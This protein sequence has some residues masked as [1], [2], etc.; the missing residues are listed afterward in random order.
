M[1]INARE[2]ADELLKCFPAVSELVNAGISEGAA[3]IIS[4]GYKL[5][6]ISNLDKGN[7]FGILDDLFSNYDCSKL[8]IGFF[9]LRQPEKLNDYEV[10]IGNYEADY[11]IANMRNGEIYMKE[12]GSPHHTLA[13]CANNIESFL[14]VILTAACFRKKKMLKQIVLNYE[15]I[16]RY[17]T[18]CIKVAGGEKYQ[19]FCKMMLGTLGYEQV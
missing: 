15:T 5:E 3:E 13:S 8:E 9:M 7:K 6:K 12:L 11:I 10:I 19:T 1:A 18:E 4:N 2:F 14:H 16:K 17:E